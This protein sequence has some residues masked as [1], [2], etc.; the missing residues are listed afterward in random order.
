MEASAL[1]RDELAA[2][3]P[4]AVDALKALARFDE[5]SFRGTFAS[6][7]RPSCALSS[8]SARRER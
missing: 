8:A 1:A 4:L 6:R 7:F 3:A 5:A 2:R